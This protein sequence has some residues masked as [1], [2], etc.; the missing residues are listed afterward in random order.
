MKKR[1]LMILPLAAAFALAGCSSDDG[2]TSETSPE[3]TQSGQNTQT[4]ETTQPEAAS[5]KA[6]DGAQVKSVVEALVAD[7][8]GAQVLDGDTIAASLPQAQAAIE[9]MNIEPAQCAELISQQGS[10]D[11]EGINMAVATVTEGTNA[12]SYSVASYEDDAKLEEARKSAES[13]D[14]QGCDSFS[15]EAQGQKLEASAELMEATSDAEVTVVTKTDITMD[16]VD[17]PM[18]SVSV[19]AIDG[20]TAVAVSASGDVDGEQQLIDQLIEEVNKA[21]AEV[22][23]V[24]Q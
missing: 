11:V 17:V 8:E 14:M 1:S 23:K 9:Q 7:K 24:Q 6:L 4:E 15:M 21:L 10:W 20:R 16:G 18:N 3:G 13:M 19:Q 2:G 5:A 12:T 22:D